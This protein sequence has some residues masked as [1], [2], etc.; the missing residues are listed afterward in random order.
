LIVSRQP[1]VILPSYDVPMFDDPEVSR[2]ANNLIAVH[3]ED[4]ATVARR[5]G[6]V[7]EDA[8]LT[9]VARHWR[10]VAAMIEHLQPCSR[11]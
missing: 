9:D 3:G 1:D 2:A 5:R 6:A 8:G 4:T 7:M 11:S 10:R